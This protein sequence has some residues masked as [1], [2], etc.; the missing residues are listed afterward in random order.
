ME[1]DVLKKYFRRLVLLTEYINEEI[2]PKI[3]EVF[4][5]TPEILKARKKRIRFLQN[6]IIAGT[7]RRCAGRCCSVPLS[8]KNL[9]SGRLWRL[10]P[11]RLQ[12]VIYFSVRKNFIIPKPDW[13]FLKVRNK[14]ACIFLSEKGCLLRDDRPIFCL[15]FTCGPLFCNMERERLAEKDIATK[16]ELHQ[17]YSGWVLKISPPEFFVFL[18]I[19]CYN[20]NMDPVRN[21]NLGIFAGNVYIEYG[22]DNKKL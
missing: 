7:C 19:F 16:K 6:E 11:M 18:I 20:K 22:Y 9:S 1:I 10:S 17:A 5:P 3:A 15:N 8:D 2:A 14:M 13:N 12:E 4:P 21:P